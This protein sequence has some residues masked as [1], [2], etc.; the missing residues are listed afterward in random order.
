MTPDVLLGL[1]SNIGDREGHVAAAV[2]RLAGRGFAV[3]ARSALYL[4]EPKDAPPQD[5]FVNAAVR[6]TTALGAEALLD[7]CLQ[8]E[9][10]LGRVR[11]V[12]RGPRTVDVDLLLYGQ[13]MRDTPRLTV[14][15]PRMHERRFVLVPLAEIA[16]DHRHPVLG[17]TVA[18]LLRDCP[19]T[20]RVSRLPSPEGWA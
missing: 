9:Q 10:E 5:W 17:R 8:V 1:G 19:D 12:H 20:S 2:S 13:E 7:V 18:E 15:H 14:P 16:P 6:G 4:T 3:H 11:A